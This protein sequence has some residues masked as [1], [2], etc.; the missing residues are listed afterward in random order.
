MP[1]FFDDAMNVIGDAASAVAD[2]AGDAVAAVEDAVT[3]TATDVAEQLPAAPDVSA[4]MMFSADASIGEMTPLFNVGPPDFMADA[5]NYDIQG[6]SGEVR[7]GQAEA[8][9]DVDHVT[10]GDVTQAGGVVVEGTR[11]QFGIDAPGVDASLTGEEVFT[12]NPGVIG[13]VPRVGG[14]GFGGSADVTITPDELPAVPAMPAV[15]DIPTGFD[16][17]AGLDVPEG[18]DM[19][20]GFDLPAAPDMPADFD[21]PDITGVSAMIDVARTPAPGAPG[22]IPI[23]YPTVTDTG[24]PAAPEPVEVDSPFEAVDITRV[25]D[26]VFEA[27][28]FDDAPVDVPPVEIDLPDFQPIEMEPPA[29]EPSPFEH[30]LAAIDDTVDGLDI[31]E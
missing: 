24:V 5:P 15:P 10:P 18:F 23:P 19:P 20:T 30:D 16:L 12:T 13:I 1:S 31:F 25:T 11:I 21:L 2:I 14:P 7:I 3:G 22:G 4:P 6:P 17:P 9:F 29:P 27:L 8:H 26:P 28:D